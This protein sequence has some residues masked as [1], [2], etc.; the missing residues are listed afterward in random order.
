MITKEPGLV[1]ITN[2][3]RLVAFIQL[4]ENKSTN[5]YIAFEVSIKVKSSKMIE[6]EIKVDDFACIWEL[7]ST[8]LL[9]IKEY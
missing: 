9:L 4:I 2:N 7:A 5:Q 8:Q 6:R 1:L 3:L